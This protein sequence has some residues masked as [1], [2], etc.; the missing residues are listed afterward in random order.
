MTTQDMFSTVAET[1]TPGVALV[2]LSNESHDALL[3]RFLHYGNPLLD[4]D[5]VLLAIYRS[6]AELPD[7]LLGPIRDFG[8]YPNLPG[9]M[10]LRNLP[11][12][13]VLPAT[14]T[15]GR[16]SPHKSTFVSECVV[17]GLSQL[18][19]EPIGYTT[20]KE[21]CLVHDVVSVRSGERTQTNQSSTVFL[22]F[23]N[24]TTYDPTGYYNVSNPDFLVLLA[25]RKSPDERGRTA[26]VD[27]RWLTDKLGADVVSTLRRADFLLNA[28]GT[29][30]RD[31]AEGADV[32]SNPVPLIQGP[33]EA[34]EISVSANGVKPLTAEATAAWRALQEICQEEGI[35]FRALLEPGDALLIDNRKG[36]H[37]R[38][39]FT[40]EY[41]GS[42]RW[43]QRC[44]VRRSSWILRDRIT[45]DRRV[46]S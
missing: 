22:S 36:L 19:G 21:G 12:D 7:N 28:P 15:D 45:S 31:H 6:F 9:A 14:P 8:R 44:Y 37:A 1:P 11:V 43:L 34:P 32:W 40:A 20:E 18:I 13:P 42:D 33:S 5:R 41:S 39:P 27:A 38:E 46:F 4:I 16:P 30:C 35:A 3:N 24:D 29:Y 2:R 26:Y 23:H 10:L 17:L 25:L